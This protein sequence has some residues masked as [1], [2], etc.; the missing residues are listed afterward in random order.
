[1]FS[2]LLL[3]SFFFHP[4][5]SNATPS[6]HIWAPS[7][8]IQPYGKIHATTDIYVPVEKNNPL[9]PNYVLQDYGLTFSLLSDKP[10]DNLLGKLWAPLG[11][12][13]AETGFDYKKGL[14]P[15]LDT[16]PWYFNF[17][18]AVP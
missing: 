13:M 2:F 16:Y 4:S 12:V 8:D 9:G 1:M 10:E 17:K 6:T 15:Y 7:T 11:K 3:S 18:L 14:G 5:F